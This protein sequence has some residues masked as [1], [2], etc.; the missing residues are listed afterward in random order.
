MK[1]VYSIL[2][3]TTLFT[4]IHAQA[5]EVTM[6]KKSDLALN[7]RQ[8]TH[9]RYDSSIRKMD[10]ESATLADKIMN[11][12]RYLASEKNNSTDNLQVKLIKK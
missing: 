11:R 5:F 2:F 4:S 6:I 7:D 8:S 3:V 12:D 9:H 10:Q 1:T